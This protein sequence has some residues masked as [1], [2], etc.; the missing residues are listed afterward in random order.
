MNLGN[1]R[2]AGVARVLVADDHPLS[3]RGVVSL[4]ANEADL[5]LCGQASTIFETRRLAMELTPDLV[6][7]DLE[8][9]GGDSFQLLEELRS[10]SVRP[11]IVA[12][13]G[14]SEHDGEAERA[15]K[16]GAAAFVSRRADG[17][18]LLRVIR[19]ALAGNIVLGDAVIERLVRQRPPLRRAAGPPRD[20]DGIACA[21]GK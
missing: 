10:S 3:R 11:K 18:E 19:S 16:L 2:P 7:L 17:E 15:L 5:A 9:H 8:M 20:G 1:E 21:L 14:S 13:A 12:L 4:I 6:I